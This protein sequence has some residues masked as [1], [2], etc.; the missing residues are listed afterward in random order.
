MAQSGAERSALNN[1]KKERWERVYGQLWKVLRKDS[2]NATARYIMA[3]YFFTPRHSG[4]NI[5]SAYHYTLGA[6]ED[7]QRSPA[8][9][10]DRMRRV[11][12]DSVILIQYRGR[13]DS[14]AFERA[15]GID[16]EQ[17]YGLFLERF[18]SAA[19]QPQAIALR[20]EAAYREVLKIN[21]HQAFQEYLVKYPGSSRAPDARIR[22]ERLLFEAETHDRQLASYEKFVRNFPASHHRN[23]AEKNIFEISTASG[24]AG[25]FENFLA[26]YPESHLV[27]AA[28]R[29][30]YHLLPD[31]QRQAALPFFLKNDSLQQ[32]LVSNRNYLVPVL[33]HAR[34][35]FIDQEGKEVIEPQA[36]EIDA[37]YRCGNITEDVLVLPD[38]IVAQ[39]GAV[40]LEGKILSLDDL[41]NGFLL[42]E[43]ENCFFVLHKS[44]FTVGDP[45]IEDARLIGGRFLSLRKNNEWSLWTLT[46]KML[47][48]YAWDSISS[49]GNVIIFQKGEKLQ[50]ATASGIAGIARRHQPLELTDAFDEVK[51]W[52]DS[53]LWVRAGDFQ[54]ALDQTLAIRIGFDKGDLTPA[55]FGA[56]RSGQPVTLYGKTGRVISEGR[57]VRVQYPWIALKSGQFWKM[58]APDGTIISKAYDTLC[59]KGPFAIGMTKDSTRIYINR[60]TILE[61]TQ[62]VSLEFIP[63]QDSSAYMLIGHDEKKSLYDQEGRKLFT[64]PCDKVQHAGQDIFMISKREKKGLVAADGK[65]LLPV[66]YDAIGSMKDGI[67]SL[68]KSMK[69][70]ALDVKHKR[71]I[72]PEYSKNLVRYNDHVLMAYKDGA[73]GF[74]GW[75]NKPLGNFEFA[76]IQYW[77]DSAAFVKKNHQWMIYDIRS[78]SVLLD[79]IK[80]YKLIR[81]TPGEKL[82]IIHHENKYGVLSSRE[83][84]M[85]PTTFTDI[86]NVGS[87]EAPLYFTE[88]HVE[89]ASLFVVIYY[90]A[91]GVMLRKEVYEQEEYE[92][93]Y[94]PPTP[95]P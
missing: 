14:A 18:R 72:K 37:V 60:T 17:A 70:G 26:C 5:D 52:S 83:G 75:D 66:E 68:L 88:K 47:L 90:S 27:S 22:Y 43:R 34:Y 10:R 71:L 19:Q 89:E 45:C 55:F 25:A 20:D 76:E 74:I 44:G 51:A 61:M 59:F 1:L 57:D 77:N 91:K 87:S 58:L 21:T 48:H 32:V 8:K 3:Q 6:L 2:T 95:G 67:V 80:D 42:V 31:E 63:G 4:Y 65:L 94:C 29:I 69:F 46:G 38:K 41:G 12:V 28:Q 62:P 15:K 13:I 30:L 16:T 73:F 93:I 35:G 36:A 53:L 50:L 56:V 23:E 82:A 40:L 39:N 49:A 81:D 64:L 24:D 9:E 33:H 7:F 79:K 78:K 85:M 11:P 92:K 84:V 54:G 86:V